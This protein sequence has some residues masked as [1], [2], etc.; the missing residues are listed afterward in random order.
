MVVLEMN[1]Q[2]MLTI[3]EM[4]ARAGMTP[5][6][7]RQLLA[8]GKIAGVRVSKNLWLMPESEFAKI[9]TP[10]RIGRPRKGASQPPPR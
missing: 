4:A 10:A 5:A 8:E 2:R 1:G 6:R 3:P 7:V 9:A